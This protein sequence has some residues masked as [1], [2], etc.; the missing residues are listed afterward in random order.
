MALAL[1]KSAVKWTSLTAEQTELCESMARGID[2]VSS[3]HRILFEH[4][5]MLRKCASANESGV[6]HVIALVSRRAEVR[7]HQSIY[8]RNMLCSCCSRRQSCRVNV[9]QTTRCGTSG[10]W[11]ST[12]G[13]TRATAPGRQRGARAARRGRRRGRARPR[14]RPPRASCSCAAG[15]DAAPCLRWVLFRQPQSGC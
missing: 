6:V 9:L 15:A 14:R 8:C 10:S 5:Q 3:Q 4:W 2:A 7:Q 11:R 12:S 1:E 13:A